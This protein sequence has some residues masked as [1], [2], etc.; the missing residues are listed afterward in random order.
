MYKNRGTKRFRLLASKSVSG[1][2]KAILQKTLEDSRKKKPCLLTIQLEPNFPIWKIFRFVKFELL[3]YWGKGGGLQH[4]SLLTDDNFDDIFGFD[5]LSFSVLTNIISINYHFRFWPISSNRLSFSVLTN[6][7]RKNA[8]WNCLELELEEEGRL[9]RGLCWEKRNDRGR[10]CWS[11]AQKTN[12]DRRGLCCM[13]TITQLSK[14]IQFW[15]KEKKSR[16]NCMNS[17]EAIIP[18][19]FLGRKFRK[20]A[21]T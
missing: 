16:S 17:T 5:Q 14:W 4:F 15:S 18:L 10:L 3:D 6:I 12:A 2:W 9:W 21:V 7:I 8:K 1:P 20:L 13:I 11:F 19:R